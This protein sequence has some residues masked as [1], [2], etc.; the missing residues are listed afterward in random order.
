MKEPHLLFKYLKYNLILVF[1]GTA[2]LSNGQ[3]SVQVIDENG[4]PL[5]GA[6]V[7]YMNKSMISD[8][9]GVVVLEPELEDSVS[10]NFS[11]I[12]YDRLNLSVKSIRAQ[13]NIVE[14]T[15][16]KGMLD[17]VVIIGRTNSRTFDVPFNIK[18]LRSKEIYNSTAQTA[19]DALALSGMAYVQKSQM[20]GGSPILRGFEANK[21]LLV[22]D[23]VRMN[24]AIYRSGHLQN[25]ITIDPAILQQTELIYGP[26]SLMYGSDALGGVI[27]FRTKSPILNYYSNKRSLHKINAYTRYNSANSE[28]TA[29]FDY[30]YSN[31]SW[32][33]TTSFSFSDFGDLVAGN[34]RSDDY[35]EFGKRNQYVQRIGALDTIVNNDNPNKQLGSAYRQYDFLQKWSYRA[36]SRLKYDLNL[37]YSTSSDIP[38]YDNL[39]EEVNGSFRY[40]DWRYGP[41]SRLLVSPRLEW[42]APTPLFDKLLLIASY[43]N[44]DEERIFKFYQDPLI[45]QQKE[46]LHVMGLTVDLEKRITNTQRLT[47]GVDIHHNDVSSI[48]NETNIITGS[49]NQNSLTRYPSG[50]SIMTV[51]G[52]YLQHTWKNQDST[53][54]WINGLRLNLQSTSFSYLQGDPVEWPDYFYDGITSE[55]KTVVGMTG[56]NY[57]KGPWLMKI[58]TGTA[59][60]APNVDDLAKIRI[61][62]NEINVPNPEL[63]AE[64]VWNSEF[65]LMH[66]KRNLSIGLTVFYTHI[67]D[68]IVRERFQLPNG[69]NAFVT[70][71]DTLLV[72]GN[73]NAETGHVRG[74][75]GTIMW[76]PAT[77]FEVYSTLSV[78]K[79]EAKDEDGNTSPLGHI[80]PTYGITK[81]SYNYKK[82]SINLLWQYNFHKDIEDFGGSVDNP[83]LATP[84][85]S[86]GW[87]TLSLQTHWQLTKKLHLTAAMNNI[88]DLH[89]RPFAS[90]ISAA[91]RHI[92]LSLKYSN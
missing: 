7:Q 2:F 10:V 76:T 32:G 39:I 34:N 56:L 49:I 13:N 83:D 73:V 33:V 86:P 5:I 12:S 48:A 79:G 63:E 29:H 70:A 16:S 65:N 72:T 64:K 52:A 58:S 31:K 89:Y 3:E 61:N 92:V 81:L 20:G 57:K 88:F 8:A 42:T 59:F 36:N 17:E 37:Q 44:V 51:L 38:R 50:G 74:I 47:Y 41:Q 80:P 27:H 23:G 18:R 24:N 4:Y 40:S 1:L 43:Q 25:A 77:N 55:D 69:D 28:K 90:G 54:N 87:Q 84:D 67:S 68:A 66:S 11:Y 46:D 9:N 75:S 6:I 21:I 14:L 26:G 78:Q 71:G 62:S 60:R 85:G 15:P 91:G 19:A 35:P 82:H 22:I 30:T 45:F 53:L